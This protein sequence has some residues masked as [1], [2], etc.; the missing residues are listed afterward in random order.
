MRCI[1]NKLIKVVIF[2]ILIIILLP[3]LNYIVD[4]IVGLGRLL[5]TCVRILGTI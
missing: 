1:D 2:L 4:A 5:G 3:I